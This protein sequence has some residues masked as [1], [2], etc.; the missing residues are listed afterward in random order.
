MGAVAKPTRAPSGPSDQLVS[1]FLASDSNYRS[2]LKN[3]SEV[4]MLQVKHPSRLV[5][6]DPG[7]AAPVLDELQ[8][9]GA[10]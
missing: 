10:A 3:A 4:R 7:D 9:T 2:F 1:A 5:A 8:R 6:A